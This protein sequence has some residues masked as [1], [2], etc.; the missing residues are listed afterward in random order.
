MKK[1]NGSKTEEVFRGICVA[2]HNDY[3]NSTFTI[4]CVGF[5]RS[6][7]PQNIAGEAVTILY[8]TYQPDIK[9]VKVL[10]C[11]ELANIVAHPRVV[12]E[13]GKEANA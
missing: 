8:S 10:L 2:K 13:Q 5:E 4:R 12:F 6:A 1:R 7:S 3:Y 11:Y 9:S